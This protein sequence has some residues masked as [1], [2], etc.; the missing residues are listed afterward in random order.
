[1]NN[2]NNSTM[3]DNS[4]DDQNMSDD[5]YKDFVDNNNQ[6]NDY[7]NNVNVNNNSI[8]HQGYQEKQ[9]NTGFLNSHTKVEKYERKNRILLFG[10]YALVLVIGVVVVLMFLTNKYQFYFKKDEVVINQGST[11]Q[12]ELTPK[13]AESFDYLNYKYSIGDESVATVDEYGTV[14][15][16]GTGKTDLKVRMKYGLISKSMKITVDNININGIVLKVQRKD[17][18]QSVNVLD[19][20]TDETITLHAFPDDRDDLNLSVSYSSS[21]TNVAIVDE[22]GNVTAKK[23]GVAVI[24]GTLNGVSGKM[25][26]R[27]NG[28]SMP[29]PTAKPKPN[30]NT[31]NNTPKVTPKVTTPPKSSTVNVENLSFSSSNVTVKVGNAYQLVV[32]VKPANA[33]EKELV[34]SSSNPSVAT[35]SDSGVVSGLKTGSAT[36]TVKNKNGTKSATCKV[37]VVTTI[38]TSTVLKGVDI[39]IV[40]TTKYVGETLQLKAKLNPTDAKVSKITWTSSNTSVATVSSEG[41]VT[42]KSPGT[43]TITVTADSYK[44]SGTIIVKAKTTATPKQATNTTAPAGTQVPASE[45]TITP[46]TLTVNKGK[47]ATFTIKASKSAGKITVTS[48]NNNVVKVSPTSIS[49]DGEEVSD[50]CN[51][52]TCFFDKWTVTYTVTGV[53]AGTAYIN[54][55]VDDMVTYD[56]KAVTGSGKIGIL[57]K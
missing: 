6:N 3:S 50:N 23:T 11:Y 49:S 15:A 36:I 54:V 31:N 35:V 4:Q 41:L 14:Q 5:I 9:Y 10:F 24:N 16:V 44:S 30:N 12:L 47:T 19:M 57:V 32:N 22:F 28:T 1:M 53:S 13:N 48:N 33:T 39:G 37:N 43:V 55:K 8:T 18:M 56:E 34:F 52:N 51:G 38:S 2:K 46:L 26:V 27:V 25:T 42:M 21:N 20:Q 17:K 7:N 29:I 45:I 40:Q